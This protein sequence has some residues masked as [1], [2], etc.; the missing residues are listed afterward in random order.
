MIQDVTILYVTRTH[1]DLSCLPTP[2]VQLG[3]AT[4]GHGWLFLFWR[5]H[6]VGRKLVDAS[7]P[8]GQATTTGYPTTT[9]CKV[10]QMLENRWFID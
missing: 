1:P 4:L 9:V 7:A 5:L 6:R 8:Q 3:D 10:V 2:S